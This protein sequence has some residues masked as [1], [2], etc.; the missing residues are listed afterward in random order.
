M[1]AVVVLLLI[2]GE[3]WAVLFCV[4]VGTLVSIIATGGGFSVAFCFSGDSD[5]TFL[6]S[7]LSI[8]DALTAF[9]S[10]I[11]SGFKDL[12]GACFGKRG[13]GLDDI[14]AAD[15]RLRLAFDSGLELGGAFG[16]N[17]LVFV[18]VPGAAPLFRRRSL[19]LLSVDAVE[20]K[21]VKE[22]RDRC[23]ELVSCGWPSS[24]AASL[25]FSILSPAVGQ[26][27]Q[28][29]GFPDLKACISNMPCL[30][31]NNFMA[32]WNLPSNTNWLA[33]VA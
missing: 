28:F 29:L 18:G 26:A 1:A 22:D 25:P 32:K 19:P 14:S 33:R 31:D 3:D 15:A 6:L 23:D 27:P 8:M 5:E 20:R 17:S 4:E 11:A 2:P 30:G 16:D 21:D 10:L 7:A 24:P 12:P 13:T 9:A